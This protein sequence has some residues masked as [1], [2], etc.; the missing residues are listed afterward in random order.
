[1]YFNDKNSDTNIDRKVKNNNKSSLPKLSINKIII[2]GVIL[3]IFIVM[4]LL[5][6]NRKPTMYMELIG[7]EVITLYQGSDYIEPG[8]KAYNSR[9]ED[10][11]NDVIIE[12]NL[13]IDKIGEYEITYTIGDIV[14]TRKINVIEKSKEY[15]YIYLN[16]INNNVNVYLKVGETYKEPGYQVFN[17]YGLDLNDK[18]E[19]TGNIDTSKKGSYVLTYSVYDSSNVKVSV[20]RTVIVMDSEINLSIENSN[21]TNSNVKINISVI[22]E[23]FDYMILPNNEKVTKST[24]TYE[25]SENGTY[26]FKTYNNKGMSKQSSIEVKNID[27]TAPSGSCSGYYQKGISTINI[28][29]NDNIGISKYMINGIS[30][31]TKNITINEQI[32]SVNIIIYDKSGNTKNISCSLED[33]NKLITS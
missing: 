18:V 26:T 23:F 16:T 13:N 6:I 10:L 27:R 28:N 14:K 30:Y 5:F 17:S 8:Y 15:T 9:D 21:Y 29:A 33:K 1:M 24:Y 7:D 11:N 32:D 19:I 25:V 31:D 12:S 22:D 2:V 20:T 4:I 3:I